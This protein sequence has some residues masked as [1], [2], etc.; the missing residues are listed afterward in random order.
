MLVT[1]LFQNKANAQEPSTS[2]KEHKMAL[3]TLKDRLWCI[4]NRNTWNG[5]FCR[6]SCWETTLYALQEHKPCLWNMSSFGERSWP[7]KL[8]GGNV[9][10]ND[11]RA[12]CCIDYTQGKRGCCFITFPMSGMLWRCW[13]R[14]HTIL[15]YAFQC[16]FS[17]VFG[18]SWLTANVVHT[19]KTQKDI[20]DS[21][22]EP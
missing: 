19:C 16:M 11:I 20:N 4:E 8:E 3:T 22:T 10:S 6:A 7:C 12:Q 18:I 13:T 21:R 5:E 14:I 17:N 1:L 9:L 15:I 2:S